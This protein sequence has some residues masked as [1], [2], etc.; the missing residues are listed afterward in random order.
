MM[1]FIQQIFTLNCIHILVGGD[2]GRSLSPSQSFELGSSN[3]REMFFIYDL[4]YL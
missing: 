1:L 3:V 4:K 2:L